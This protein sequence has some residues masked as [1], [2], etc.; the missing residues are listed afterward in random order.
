MSTFQS[1]LFEQVAKVGNESEIGAQVDC[2][3][4]ETVGS[5]VGASSVLTDGEVVGLALLVIVVVSSKTF[6]G[7]SEVAPSFPTS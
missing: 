2:T 5:L 6:L 4:E 1:G 7:E 3:V